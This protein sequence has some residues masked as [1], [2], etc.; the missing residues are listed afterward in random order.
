MLEYIEY[1]IGVDGAEYIRR[2]QLNVT[3]WQF[4]PTKV[5]VEFL[6]TMLSFSTPMIGKS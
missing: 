5:I 3:E 4:S 1:Q 2:I 6:I